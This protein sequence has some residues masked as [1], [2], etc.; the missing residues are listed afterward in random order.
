MYT[1]IEERYL[2]TNSIEKHKTQLNFNIFLGNEV[3]L[4]PHMK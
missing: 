3:Q 1:F 4:Y 2:F